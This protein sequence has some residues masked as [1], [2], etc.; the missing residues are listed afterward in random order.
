M[1]FKCLT[2]NIELEIQD[3]K[4]KFK[5]LSWAGCPQCKLF[6]MK[7]PREGEYSG[8]KIVRVS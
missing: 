4:R 3:K 2:H 5:G 7:E 8:C 1:K 6:T